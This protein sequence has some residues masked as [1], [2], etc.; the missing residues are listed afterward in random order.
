V[1][2]QPPCADPAGAGGRYTGTAS[3][4]ARVRSRHA[5]SSRTLTV[6]HACLAV[7]A[8]L[9]WGISLPLVDLSA[10]SGWGMLSAVPLTWWFAVASMVPYLIGALQGRCPT[11]VLCTYHAA[12]LAVLF[13][14][15]AATYRTPRFPWTY[16]HVGVVEHMLAT[17]QVDRSIDI[18][19]NWPGF[20]LAA[21][22]VSRFT[23]VSTLDLARW[24]EPC[25]A[26]MVSGALVFAVHGVTRDRRLV[27]VTLLVFTLGNWVGQNYFAP[28]ALATVFALLFLGGVVRWLP[29]RDP[30][31]RPV[32]RRLVAVLNRHGQPA[33]L[34]VSP[35]RPPVWGLPLATV[36]F[37]GVVVTHQL[38][39]VAVLMQ[40]LL[41]A[42]L[43]RVRRPWVILV[44]IILEV[45][46]VAR[47]WTFVSS[48]W[49]IFAPDGIATPESAARLIPSLP[50]VDLVSK[51]P[52][53]LVGIMC[54]LAGSAFI[55]RY[56]RRRSLEVV[57]FAFAAAPP[58]L[59]PV[60]SY[61]GEGL[62]RAYLY[63][64]PWIAYLVARMVLAVW[65]DVTWTRW[66]LTACVS[67]VTCVSLCAMLG[68]ELVVHVPE[69]D[70]T[71]SQ[72]FE[73]NTPE[74]SYA[75]Q[76]AGAGVP[77]L[78]TENYPRHLHPPV[79]LNETR[80]FN[81][82]RTPTRTL[83]ALARRAFDEN[84]P[85]GY[86]VMTE[87]QYTYSRV[88]GQASQEQIQ[89]LVAA[90]STSAEY[91]VVYHKHR[92]LIAEYLGTAVPVGSS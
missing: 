19:N 42:V 12:L 89:A 59:V 65:S 26:L 9:L 60:Q 1:S 3:T 37:A 84:G 21:A 41:L 46:W 43:V 40:I 67:G 6:I 22:F 23:G 18:Y 73:T 48:R 74:G 4:P 68:S 39:P 61:G 71:A 62:F 83:L 45:A 17:G 8:F 58:L 88:Y 53:A 87:E 85:G 27:W 44:W 90:I 92:N 56:L 64:L 14:T 10:L 25:F 32:P 15:T 24:A 35:R 54:L 49:S 52:M 63:A 29:I 50:G 55:W 28:Q 76:L 7:S 82:G 36:L 79:A 2:T 75:V 31:D 11:W 13:G 81:P 51:T 33:Q 16:K 30:S 78:V 77:L 5:R 57:A 20:F 47:A 69:Q 66:V 72:W 91:R 38:T 70:V 34:A 80:E 86:F